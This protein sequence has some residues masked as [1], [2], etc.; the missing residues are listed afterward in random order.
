LLKALQVKIQE[1]T[2]CRFRNSKSDWL[3]WSRINKN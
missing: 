2:S 1:H 3:A